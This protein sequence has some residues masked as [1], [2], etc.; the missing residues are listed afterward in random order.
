MGMR[1]NHA[2]KIIGESE[3]LGRGTRMH[4]NNVLVSGSHCLTQGRSAPIVSGLAVDHVEYVTDA[5]HKTMMRICDKQLLPSVCETDVKN[6]TGVRIDS[7]V[8]DNNGQI[9]AAADS[10]STKKNKRA[11][12][13]KQKGKVVEAP[14]IEPK[15]DQSSESSV[16]VRDAVTVREAVTVR[17]A[18]SQTADSFK[19]PRCPIL[20]KEVSD[21]DEELKVARRA[22]Q[23]F[24][25]QRHDTVDSRLQEAGPKKGAE[26]NKRG[27]E[28]VRRKVGGSNE[29]LSEPS[30]Q[31][32]EVSVIV[33]RESSG[34]IVVV[35]N[36][37]YGLLCQLVVLRLTDCLVY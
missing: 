1:K 24:E 12:K 9:N 13:S 6:R 11:A 2:E 23:I 32:I 28:A 4:G 30:A 26:L 19:C 22:I 21:L 35:I 37:R 31:P 17:D 14:R 8:A 27:Q 18:V 20:E 25:Q 33:D 7:A 29:N 15:V 36:T 16:T 34:L 3:G 10:S 5:R